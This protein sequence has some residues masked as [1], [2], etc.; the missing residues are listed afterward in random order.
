MPAKIMIT[1]ATGNLGRALVPVLQQ[2]GAELRLL[3][4]SEQ[5]AGDGFEWVRGDVS[6]GEG[7]EVA[8]KGVDTIVHCAGSAQGDADKAR[9]VVE[10]A[11]A[12]GVE[13]LVHVS[14]VGA[15]T[16]PVVGRIDHSMFGYFAAKREAEQVVMGSPI[17]W[18]M[19]RPTQFHSFV[20]DQLD[21]LSRTPV[22]LPVF[23]GV[24]FQP[25]DVNDVAVRLG[26]LALADPAGIAA[27]I[28]GPRIYS[29]DQLAHDYLTATGKRRVVVNLP[30][31]GASVKAFRAGANMVPD[32]ATGTGTWEAYL[33]ERFGR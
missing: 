29:F 24:S 8:V 27:P 32:Y 10:A 19:L 15:D 5:P 22:L 12:A 4:R 20:V 2:A 7:L 30:V 13:H 9:H 6:T 18:T 25:V 3:S 23:K 17:P 1:G 28:G 26:E 14:V 21:Q 31:P 11:A 16:I 33:A